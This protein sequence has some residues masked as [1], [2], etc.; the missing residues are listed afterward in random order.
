MQK[1]DA[2]KKSLIGLTAFTEN[3]DEVYFAENS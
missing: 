3:A 1:C 2:D